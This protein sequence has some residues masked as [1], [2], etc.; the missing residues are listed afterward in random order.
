MGFGG[1]CVWLAGWLV[2]YLVFVVGVLL[3]LD[4]I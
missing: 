2:W 3:V 4:V 1:A